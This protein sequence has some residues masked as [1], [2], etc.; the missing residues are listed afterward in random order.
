MHLWGVSLSV[1]CLLLIS[2]GPAH[3]YKVRRDMSY[4]PSDPHPMR[5]VDVYE[6]PYDA[7]QRR[8]V[9]LAIHG[10]AWRSGDKRSFGEGVAKRFCPR[11][12]V[13]LSI[14]YRLSTEARWPAQIED[15]RR[16]GV[17]CATTPA[18]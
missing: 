4:T 5:G 17:G 13:V 12:Y 2:C 18:R 15:C 14:N 6:P 1:A 7:G 8:A 3:P 16:H 10:G 9:I 11:G